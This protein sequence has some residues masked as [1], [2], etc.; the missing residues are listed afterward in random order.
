MIKGKIKMGRKSEEW[1]EQC[2]EVFNTKYLQTNCPHCG[3]IVISC[4]NCKIPFE[5]SLWILC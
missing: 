4:N 2:G 5:D 3:K 1:C